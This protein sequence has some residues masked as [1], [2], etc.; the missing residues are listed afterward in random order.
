MF[1]YNGVQNHASG[2]TL[3]PRKRRAADLEHQRPQLPRQP[4]SAP[5]YGGVGA[6]TITRRR[7]FRIARGTWTLPMGN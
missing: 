7:P 3:L 4:F 2:N 1:H 6:G 5:I